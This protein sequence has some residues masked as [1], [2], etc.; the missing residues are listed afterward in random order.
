MDAIDAARAFIGSSFGE[1]HQMQDSTKPSETHTITGLATSDSSDG[2]VRVDLMGYTVS[3]DGEQSLEL[4][5]TVDVVEGDTVQVTLVGGTGKSPIVTGVVGGGDRLSNNVQD[6]V[7]TAQDAAEAVAEVADVTH[8]F[9]HDNDGAHVTTE[10]DDATTGHNTLIDSNGMYVRDGT[11]NLAQFTNPTIIGETA[12]GK[13]NIRIGDIPN[14][15]N[16]LGIFKGSGMA[17]MMYGDNSSGTIYSA[18]GCYLNF[19][20]GLNVTVPQKTPFTILDANR[21]SGFTIGGY[22][23]YAGTMVQTVQARSY[24]RVWTNAQF[25]STFHVKSD[26]AV[27]S[28]Y[29][30]FANGDAAAQPKQLNASYKDTSGWFMGVDGTLGAGAFRI[31]YLVVVLDSDSTV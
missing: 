15:S 16:G 29:V 14:W 17:L 1:T 26:S 30:Q 23:I 27:G 5:T 31:N 21:Q 13:M 8:Y 28:C 4:P 11:T 25:R 7:Q 22:H 12:T 10:P 2:L 3:E 24:H 18:L 6:A 19:T 9:W 20:D